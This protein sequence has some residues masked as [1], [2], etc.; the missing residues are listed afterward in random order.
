MDVKLWQISADPNQPRQLFEAEDLANLKKSVSSHGIMNPLVV[1]EMGPGKYLLVDGERRYRV[2]KELKLEEVPVTVLKPTSHVEKL[3][4]QFHIQE[5][6]KAWTPTE[7][8]A[9]VHDLHTELK[10]PWKD[11]CDLLAINQ[12][13]AMAYNAFATLQDRKNFQ[14]SELSLEWAEGIRSLERVIDLMYEKKGE[15]Y[16]KA[17]MIIL[18]RA[19]VKKVHDN[20]IKKRGDLTKL[21]DA[22]T[23]D[24][25]SI[26]AFIKDVDM[27][28]EMIFAKTKAKGASAARKINVSTSWLQGYVNDYIEASDVELPEETIVKVKLTIKKLQDLLSHVG[29]D[30]E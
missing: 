10:L 24:P 11:M 3:V 2:A 29:S 21:K 22:F 9:A 30:K 12:R 5:Q 7:K 14:K 18:E 25:S 19:L 15:K 6:H 13:T 1:Q 26:K 20:V 27:T 16:P 17:D 8:A 28:A 23:K 4:Q